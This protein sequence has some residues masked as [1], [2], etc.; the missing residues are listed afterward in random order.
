MATV[1]KV[2]KGKRGIYDKRNKVNNL[3]GKEW[4]KMSKSVWISERKGIDKDAF[5]HPAPF[6]VEDVKKLI[7]LFTK[8]M[9][10]WQ[11]FSWEVDQLLLH[12]QLQRD[13][14]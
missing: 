11:I 6:L 1:L 12:Q 14:V 3:T 10:V 13:M 9:I 4:L 8:K 2:D 5:E 7:L